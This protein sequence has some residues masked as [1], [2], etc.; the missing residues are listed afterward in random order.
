MVGGDEEDC[1]ILTANDRG[2][3]YN[4]LA[5]DFTIQIKT[6]LKVIICGVT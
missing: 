6:L 3:T 1:K 2:F 5:W 4:V